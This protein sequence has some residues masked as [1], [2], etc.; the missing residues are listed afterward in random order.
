MKKTREQVCR[1]RALAFARQIEAQV[2]AH[3]DG[4]ELKMGSNKTAELVG[5]LLLLKINLMTRDEFEQYLQ[6]NRL[7]SDD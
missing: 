4:M 7:S 1:K 3:L 5:L 2:H 6:D